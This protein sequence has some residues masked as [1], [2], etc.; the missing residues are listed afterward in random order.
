MAEDLARLPGAVVL[1]V[2][3]RCSPTW[4]KFHAGTGPE[5]IGSVESWRRYTVVAVRESSII[6][7][8]AWNP[9]LQPAALASS[10]LLGCAALLEAL[11]WLLGV[12]RYMGVQW[13]LRLDPERYYLHAASVQ[14]G[15]SA[16]GAWPMAMV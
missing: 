4:G 8:E 9:D 6:G 11:F 13:D 7:P 12:L 10:P 2:A 15:Q 1:L 3:P 14:T 5:Q 16:C